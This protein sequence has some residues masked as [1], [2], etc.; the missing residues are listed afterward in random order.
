MNIAAP[1]RTCPECGVAFKATHGRQAFCLPQHKE[2]FHNRQSKRGKVAISLVQVWRAGKNRKG[3][4]DA[5]FA[6][7]EVCALADRW[8][9]EDK[10]AGRR[11]DLVVTRKRRNGW[12]G[13][14]LAN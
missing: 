10:A 1:N 5:T 14:D 9:Q 6:F 11:P 3:G 8:N 7:R 12:S 13:V 4:E 2:T